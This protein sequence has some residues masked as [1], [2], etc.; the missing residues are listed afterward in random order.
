M[1]TQ[2][3]ALLG[4]LHSQMVYE[5]MRFNPV[6]METMILARFPTDVFIKNRWRGRSPVLAS[7]WLLY[8]AFALA[9]STVG[10]IEPWPRAILNQNQLSQKLAALQSMCQI[11]YLFFFSHSILGHLLGLVMYTVESMLNEDPHI[12]PR[13]FPLNVL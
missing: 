3:T 11:S 1:G 5:V 10:A 8:G 4:Q 12:W 9:A 13:A 7:L 2:A 6:Y